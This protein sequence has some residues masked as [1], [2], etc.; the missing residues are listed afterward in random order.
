MG[1]INSEPG[2]VN[3]ASSDFHLLP[4]SPCIDTGD[5][6]YVA[7]P[8]AADIDGQYRVWDGDGDGVA[9][10]DMG[11]DEFGSF[12]FGDMNCDAAVNTLDIEAFVLALT[13]PTGYSTQYP[14]C[15]IDLADINA[16]GAVDSLDIEA[17]VDLLIE[18]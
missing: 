8:G 16:D 14:D 9:R 6:N 10:V 1:N 17:F 11:A 2:F 3:I 5:P 18:P 4:D 12:I 15:H 13:D 7:G